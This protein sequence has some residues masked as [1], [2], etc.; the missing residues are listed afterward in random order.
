MA[1]RALEAKDS[2]SLKAHLPQHL[3]ASRIR[4]RWDVRPPQLELDA[5]NA[6][7]EYEY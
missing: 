5:S 2:N 7:F 4:G 1:L 6:A 3:A